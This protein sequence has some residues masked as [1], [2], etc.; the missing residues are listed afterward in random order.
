MFISCIKKFQLLGTLTD[1]DL[2]S[3]ILNGSN[4]KS[5]ITKYIIKTPNLLI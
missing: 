5:S 3:A 2:R 1:G 4:L